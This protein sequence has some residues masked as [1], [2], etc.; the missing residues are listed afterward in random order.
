MNIENQTVA[1]E[2]IGSEEV[3][4]AEVGTA[5]TTGS[6]GE[7]APEGAGRLVA[8]PLRSAGM[9]LVEIMIV[10][11]IMAGIAAIVTVNVM[12][13]MEN[14]K[15]ETAQT[16]TGR[17]RTFIET[18]YTVHGELPDELSDLAEDQNGRRAFVENISPD[19]WGNDYHYEKTNNGRFQ[20]YS[21]GPDGQD[22][23]DDDIY[24][25]NANPNA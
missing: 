5:P 7:L 17:L 3:A 13:A 11:T 24:P 25:E 19:P 21:T 15:I 14:A 4:P 20:V 18:Y 16:E 22:G 2:L 6:A 1:A 8:V 9:T 10:L 12:G 23:T